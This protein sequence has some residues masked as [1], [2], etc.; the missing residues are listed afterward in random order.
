M[1]VW[2]F[3]GHRVGMLPGCVPAEPQLNELLHIS[4]HETHMVMYTRGAGPEPETP[5]REGDAQPAVEGPLPARDG[6]PATAAAPGGGCLGVVDLQRCRWLVRL[7]PAGAFGG[8][9]E[10]RTGP[11][12]SALQNVTALF[13][14]EAQR[15]IYTGTA[16]GHV[17][18]WWC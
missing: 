14:D 12:R 11:E 1:E 9:G 2:D 6:Q 10:G 17:H 18:V 4:R 7:C 3:Q 8:T 16:D 13:Y 5:Q 15:T